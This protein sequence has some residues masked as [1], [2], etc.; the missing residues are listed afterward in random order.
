MIF[1][2]QCPWCGGVVP[3]SLWEKK[4]CPHCGEKIRI[5]SHKLE[6]YG[7][8]LFW[9]IPEDRYAFLGTIAVVVFVLICGIGKGYWGFWLYAAVFLISLPFI[10]MGSLSCPFVRNVERPEGSVGE[11]FFNARIRWKVRSPL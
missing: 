3:V 9:N 1:R 6:N 8:R 7:S 2:H 5:Y 4:N 11:L 10:I